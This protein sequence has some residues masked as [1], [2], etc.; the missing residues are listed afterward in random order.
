M[1]V[2]GLTALVVLSLM[3]QIPSA[4]IVAQI[5]WYV[6]EAVHQSYILTMYASMLMLVCGIAE[7]FVLAVIFDEIDVIFC[8]YSR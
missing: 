2:V 4:Y 3:H 8:Y 1:F 7:T 6:N 5:F